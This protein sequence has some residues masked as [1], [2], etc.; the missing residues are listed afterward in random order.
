MG[1][2]KSLNCFACV[3]RALL[4]VALA[5]SVCASARAVDVPN[6]NP[7]EEERA[8][9]QAREAMAQSNWAEALARLEPHVQVHP[10]SADAFNLLGY[11]RRQLGRY[12]QALDAYQRALTIDPDHLG[13]L[14]YL[15]ELMLILHRR[16][17]AVRHLRQLERLCPSGC[18]EVEDLRRAIDRYDQT[19]G[20]R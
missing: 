19:R 20:P 2:M 16:G 17:D 12:P 7:P 10:D 15:G 9:R 6:R 5:L 11:A 8:V 4:C 13:A 18:D 3:T 1:V 14:E